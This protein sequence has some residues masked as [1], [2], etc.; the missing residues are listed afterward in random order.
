MPVSM[1]VKEEKEKRERR[2]EEEEKKEEEKK[3]REEKRRRREGRKE[4]RREREFS[5]LAAPRRLADTTA[6]AGWVL[7]LWIM[8]VGRS[9]LRRGASSA[10]T[11]HAGRDVG[12]ASSCLRGAA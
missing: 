1:P 10:A 12:G 6:P 8:S 3:K 9:C 11:V 2:E 5:G 4:E 7:L